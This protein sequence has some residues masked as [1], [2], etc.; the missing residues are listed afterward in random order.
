MSHPALK[1]VLSRCRRLSCVYCFC[2]VKLVL[3]DRASRELYNG[4]HIIVSIHFFDLN[5]ENSG[6]G[7]HFGIA[8]GFVAHFLTE[9]ICQK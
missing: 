9:T 2:C 5:G 6:C 8:D 4:R 7:C 3:I 1:V